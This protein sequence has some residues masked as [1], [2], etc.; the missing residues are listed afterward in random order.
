MA[1]SAK[2]LIFMDALPCSGIIGLPPGRKQPILPYVHYSNLTNEQIQQ[3]FTVCTCSNP[4]E[5]ME[6]MYQCLV[7]A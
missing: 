3:Y 1:L 2:C 6:P 5:T 7:V 4:L